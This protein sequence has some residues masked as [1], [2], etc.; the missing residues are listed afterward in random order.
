[1]IGDGRSAPIIVNESD[2]RSSL[3]HP[4]KTKP[5]N[6]SYQLLE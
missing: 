5:L 1:M 2:V 4:N 6:G 3:P